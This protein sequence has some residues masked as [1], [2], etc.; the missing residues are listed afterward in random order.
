MPG[1]FITAVNGLV[2]HFLGSLCINCAPYLLR[3]AAEALAAME[4]PAPEIE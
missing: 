4:V 2:D 1:G 3:R